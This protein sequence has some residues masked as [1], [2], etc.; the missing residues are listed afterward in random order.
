MDNGSVWEKELHIVDKP[1]YFGSEFHVKILV[2]LGHDAGARHPLNHLPDYLHGG[3]FLSC[4][5]NGIDMVPLISIL[6]DDT[7]GCAGTGGQATFP[8][9]DIRGWFAGAS[10]HDD[11]CQQDKGI[12]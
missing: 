10:E 3:G 8:D 12:Q 6:A 5:G 4:I 2:G 1:H 11:T 7:V 9:A